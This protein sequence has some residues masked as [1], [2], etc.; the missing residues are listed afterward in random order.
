[1]CGSHPGS[2]EASGG[3]VFEKSPARC[4]ALCGRVLSAVVVSRRENDEVLQSC[5][6]FVLYNRC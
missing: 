2:V 1:M 5:S 4:C 6:I 3:G